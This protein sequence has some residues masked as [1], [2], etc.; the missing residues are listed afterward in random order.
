MSTLHRRIGIT[1]SIKLPHGVRD[2]R[3]REIKEGTWGDVVK[4]RMRR[5]RVVMSM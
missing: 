4:S 2:W 1:S 3:R 5:M